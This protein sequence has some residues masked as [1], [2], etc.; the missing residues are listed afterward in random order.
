MLVAMLLGQAMAFDHSHTALGE[1]LAGA[2]KESRVDYDIV[3][4]RGAVLD[5]YLAE[6]AAVDASAFNDAEKLALYVN[7]YN[8]YTLRTVVDARPLASIMELDV[9]KLWDTRR[10]SVA[11]EK[12]TLNQMENDHVR[13]LADG[14][15]HAVLNC[16]A[17]G[18]P[19]L[20]A[21]PFRSVDT[22]AQ[23]HAA[24]RGWAATNA[25]RVEGDTLHLSMIFDWYGADFLD[26]RAEDLPGID[27][28]AEAAVW[29]LVPYL[30][31]ADGD[32]LKGGDLKIAWE[33]YD[34][35]LNGTP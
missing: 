25:Y 26:K 21:A 9:G 5:R 8:A 24:S 6:V 31:R 12:L 33:N 23:L 32:R 18:C 10:F 4:A 29:F 7:A 2:V 15:A 3:A 28:K 20:R 14:R 34:W 17:R 19:P 30:S 27:G 13:K 16:A 1:V 22:D 11:G 35:R